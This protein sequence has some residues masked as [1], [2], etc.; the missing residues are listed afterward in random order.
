MGLIGSKFTRE[1]LDVYEAC[2]CLSGAEILELH[3]KFSDLGG[4]RAVDAADEKV[5]RGKGADLRLSAPDVESQ[6][7]STSGGGGA[8]KPVTK[9]AFCGQYEFRNNPFK[10]RLC[11]IFSSK[12]DGSLTFDEFVDLYHCMSPRAAKKDKIMTA[13]RMYDFDGDGYL[14]KEDI[15]MIV[16]AVSRSSTID[17][18]ETKEGDLKGDIVDTVMRDCAHA[19]C[20]RPLP[21]MQA[22]P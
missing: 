18:L 3:Q 8:G 9:D 6:S 21:H 5:L 2:T 17:L 13:F 10:E 20:A 14:K 1:E 19:P 15:K 16:D 4:V 7:T 22:D 11:Q 12:G